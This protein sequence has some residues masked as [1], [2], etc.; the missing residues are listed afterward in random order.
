MVHKVEVKIWIPAQSSCFSV[1]TC[2][3]GRLPWGWSRRPLS[4]AL[5]ST[6]DD[7]A[8]CTLIHTGTCANDVVRTLHTGVNDLSTT[9][10]SIWT[11][12][13]NYGENHRVNRGRRLKR[14][15]VATQLR[16]SCCKLTLWDIRAKEEAL[17]LQWCTLN[18][19]WDSKLQ[20]ETFF[21]FYY[22]FLSLIFA[23]LFHTPTCPWLLTKCKKRKKKQKKR[24]LMWS[25]SV[26]SC[27]SSMTSNACL[28]LICNKK[29]KVISAAG[30]I[31]VCLFCLRALVFI[32]MK[33][34]TA[35]A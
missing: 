31:I 33:R 19:A 28:W 1:D 7:T 15:A 2:C 30:V 22:F 12:K 29:R 35:A 26:N 4:R 20:E 13:E 18:T 23:V 21:L 25:K 8:T 6:T 16:H 17:C 9:R 3:K 5:S 14:A 27:L 32:L 34:F 10:C 11:C 24:G